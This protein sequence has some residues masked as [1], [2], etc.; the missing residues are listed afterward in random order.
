MTYIDREKEKD[1][2]YG[3]YIY[4]HAYIIYICVGT[5]IDIYVFATTR[6]VAGI[7]AAAGFVP[8]VGEAAALPADPALFPLRML[9]SAEHSSAGV[10]QTLARCSDLC[11]FRISRATA[12]LPQRFY[13]FLRI[14]QLLEDEVPN[15]WGCPPLQAPAQ[16]V[17]HPL[18]CRAIPHWGR[19]LSHILEWLFNLKHN[20]K[21]ISNT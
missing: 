8:G 20:L 13:H 10:G 11:L 16:T 1:D 12:H 7:G 3:I 19:S 18:P 21:H 5:N 17:P 4:I 6:L 14:L 15:P 2:K 9:K